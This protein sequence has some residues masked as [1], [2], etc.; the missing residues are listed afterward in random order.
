MSNNLLALAAFL[1]VMLGAPV[2]LASPFR[3]WMRRQP[4]VMERLKDSPVPDQ[5]IAIAGC[6]CA[7]PVALVLA[8]VAAAVVLRV[9]Q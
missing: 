6:G 4:A 1:V 2:I 5:G 8:I 3:W 7:M 9:L